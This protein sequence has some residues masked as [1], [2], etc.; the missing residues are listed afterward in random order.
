MAY[1][2]GAIAGVVFLEDAEHLASSSSNS[3]GEL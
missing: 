1:M 2:F 3:A